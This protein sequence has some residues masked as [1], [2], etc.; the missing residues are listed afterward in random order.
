MDRPTPIRTE[1]LLLRGFELADA[2]QVQRLAGD[3]AIADTTGSI[4]HP[5]SDGLA[6]QWIAGHPD[7]FAQGTEVT[8][9]IFFPDEQ[10]TLDLI[11]CISLIQIDRSSHRA[12]LGYW[13]GKPFWNRGYGTEAARAVVR[14]GFEELGLN[15]IYAYHFTRNP[16]SG[17]IL[18]KIGLKHEGCLRQHF[19]KGERFEDLEIYGALK[20]EW[21]CSVVSEIDQ[22]L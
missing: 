17:R 15:R 14:Y 16:A 19:R 13:I 1:R 8:F 12:E 21:T 20:N 11:G 4:P 6:E 3:P 10:R 5:Y 18:Q 7:K 2:S 22:S 9:G